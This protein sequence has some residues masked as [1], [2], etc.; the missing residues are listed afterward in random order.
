MMAEKLAI[1]YKSGRVL[2]I[3]N[4]CI[5][6]LLPPA[7]VGLSHSM[8]LKSWDIY[9]YFYVRHMLGPEKPPHF[10]CLYNLNA[11]SMAEISLSH[12]DGKV[13]PNVS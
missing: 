12:P 7:C 13:R 9:L 8:W 1:I 4:T 6:H 3:C 5:Q 2:C 11:Y 10:V